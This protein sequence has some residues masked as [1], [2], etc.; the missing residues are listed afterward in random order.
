MLLGG[1]VV[2]VLEEPGSDPHAVA[3]GGRHGVDGAVPKEMRIDRDAKLSERGLGDDLPDVG[4]GQGPPLV[5]GQNASA[6]LRKSG[7][8]RS[9]HGRYVL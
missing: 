6:G 8:Q 4:V 2:G 3:S 7:R 5:E 9:S 1:A